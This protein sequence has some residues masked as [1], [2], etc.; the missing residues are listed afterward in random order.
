MTTEIKI[1]TRVN[2][3]TGT[4]MRNGIVY[5]LDTANNRVFVDWPQRGHSSININNLIVIK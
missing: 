2:Y 3:K 4:F 1:G 5:G